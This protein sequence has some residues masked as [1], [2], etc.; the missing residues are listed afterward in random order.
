MADLLKAYQRADRQ[1]RDELRRIGE[2]ERHETRKR[3]L[4]ALQAEIED[5]RANLDAD[6]RAWVEET[7]PKIYRLGG[8]AAAAEVG[9]TFTFTQLHRTALTAMANDTMR[10][11]LA[12]NDNIAV[13]AR[14][15]VRASVKEASLDKLLLGKTAVQASR[16]LRGELASRAITA[17]TYKNGAKHQIGDYAD[18]VI[19]SVTARA[20]NIGT[21]TEAKQAGVRYAVC[22]DGFGC[23]LTSHES[24][25]KPDGRI[26]PLGTAMRHLTS[27]P[28][29][30]RAWS[31]LPSVR[32]R[33]QADEL[34]ASGQFKRSAEQI[35]DE[36]KA[37]V[38]RA[39]KQRERRARI[40]ARERR[41]AE[42]KARSQVRAS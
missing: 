38:V 28:R 26:Y 20:Y 33:K 25:E 4:R 34:E 5:L 32:S 15:L 9:T 21:L 35:E 10:S 40:A 14:R 16:E 30:R 7:L 13:A 6:A 24:E 39:T 2:A 29:C 19:R 18:M 41:Q 11:L 22:S 27:H 12:G 8:V 17:I 42:R 36:R 1:I 37:D 3:R 31:P 23:G